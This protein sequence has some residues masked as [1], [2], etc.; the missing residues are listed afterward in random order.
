M[1][2]YSAAYSITN[3]QLTY[4]RA[5]DPEI[6]SFQATGGLEIWFIVQNSFTVGFTDLFIFPGP[7]FTPALMY[8]YITNEMTN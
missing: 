7:G 3:S 5:G 4:H 2:Y 1:L 8:D 6:L